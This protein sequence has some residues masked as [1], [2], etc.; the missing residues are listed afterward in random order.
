[1]PTSIS[2]GESPALSAPGAAPAPKLARKARRLIARIRRDPQDGTA[3]SELE[4]HYQEVGDHAS[5]ANLLAGWA[6]TLVDGRA[7]ADAMVRGADAALIGL[8]DRERA[9]A[10]LEHA[11]GRCP[12]HEVALQQLTHLLVASKD[13]M[14]L[15]TW[16]RRVAADLEGEVEHRAYL[17]RIEYRL[18]KLYEDPFEQP[19]KAALHYRRAIELEPSM[20]SAITAAR[21]LYQKT[22]NHAAVASLYE[23][24]VRA[25]RDEDDQVQLLTELAHVQHA[26][27]RDHTEA[28]RALRKALQLAP[29]NTACL[30]MLADVLVERHRSG[31]GRERDAERAAELY[32]RAAGLVP[33][34]EAVR[35]LQLSVELD[36]GHPHAI[37]LLRELRGE[38]EAFQ[39][40]ESHAPAAPVT[41]P[42]GAPR[43]AGDDDDATATSPLDP[44]RTQA[45]DPLDI[46]ELEAS[47]PDLRP[48]DVLPRRARTQP[49]TTPPP[50]PRLRSSA[51]GAEAGTAAGSLA[52]LAAAAMQPARPG[53]GMA[54]ADIGRAAVPP[55]PA[56]STPATHATTTARPSLPPPP[57]GAT[58]DEV[59]RVAPAATLNELVAHSQRESVTGWLQR[60]EPE[61]EPLGTQSLQPIDGETL[62][63]PPP[64]PA[65]GG[66]L[67]TAAV[68]APDG[69][70][71]DTKPVADQKS[72][73]AGVGRQ[74][75]GRL[76]DRL[77]RRST[78]PSRPAPAPA[79]EAPTARP[80]QLV[81]ALPPRSGRDPL[82][83]NIGPTTESN[84]YTGFDGSLLE[85]GVFIATYATLPLNLPVELTVT[86]PGDYVVTA[87]GRV[88]FVR[89]I[90]D[91][92][93]RTEPG[94][95]VQFEA[96]TEETL[97]LF[98][99]F[100]EKRQPIFFD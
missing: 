71:S 79:D 1:M 92:D 40:R 33:L 24:Q 51:P 29:T 72:S 88:R 100:A 13:Q 77:K 73:V 32:Y 96:M 7:A 60:E 31:D 34:A 45:L 75:L 46:E 67:R 52:A 80:H 84:F 36:H 76:R 2:T 66:T 50:P 56:P 23:F 98:E 30:T 53:A 27:L 87:L 89:D 39:P 95:G 8:G 20:L 12:A 18:G 61:R 3:V 83:A 5:L 16:L 47:R 97:A 22:E 42:S 86:L 49:R 99:R 59:T 68:S 38:L 11:L 64:K 35:I 58:D 82:E 17:A 19:G 91:F 37:E 14:R 4:A 78:R 81:D 48:P 44:N 63:E 55:A 10:F 62:S 9:C 41:G 21:R 43:A 65:P 70:A 90:F 25:T 93:A 85:G 54:R 69:T 57:V 74:A 94:I 26:K 28:V 6:E 15:R